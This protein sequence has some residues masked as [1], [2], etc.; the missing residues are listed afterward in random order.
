[1]KDTAKKTWILEHRCKTDDAIRAI[2]AAKRQS[3]SAYDARLRKLNAFAEVLFVKN[4][5]SSQLDLFEPE[6]AL[7]MEINELLKNPLGGL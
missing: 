2:E 5:D 4:A 7:S 3:A 6:E 1:M